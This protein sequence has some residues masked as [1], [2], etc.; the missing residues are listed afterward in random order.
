MVDH[1]GSLYG[2]DVA[3]DLVISAILGCTLLAIFLLAFTWNIKPKA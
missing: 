2:A 3:W 1:Y